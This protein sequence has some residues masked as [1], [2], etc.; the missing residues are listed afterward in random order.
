MKSW[1]FSMPERSVRWICHCRRTRPWADGSR[2]NARL[3]VL[4]QFF[5]SGV[6][7]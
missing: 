7:V 2:G 5:W 3:C 6:D 4:L 1:P